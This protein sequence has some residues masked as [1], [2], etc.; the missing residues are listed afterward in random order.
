MSSTASNPASQ[1]QRR[2]NATRRRC[3][4]R[5]SHNF[6][7]CRDPCF[8]WPLA[9]GWN[10][11][12][13]GCLYFPMTAVSPGNSSEPASAIVGSSALAVGA[14]GVVFGDIGTSPLYTL[15]TAFATLDGEATPDH[16]LGLLSLVFWTMIVI[17]TV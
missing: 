12:A 1:G 4:A 17:T 3:A 16:I 5:L 8:L 14:L 7:I 11:A 15:K 10:S 13:F 9:G 2:C 6:V